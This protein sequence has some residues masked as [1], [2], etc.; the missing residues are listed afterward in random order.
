MF[1]TFAVD[2]SAAFLYSA[3]SGEAP[4]S[5]PAYL[6]LQFPNGL[7]AIESTVLLV[8]LN[9]VSL[10]FGLTVAMRSIRW[11]SRV[12]MAVAVT[13]I[14][15]DLDQTSRLIGMSIAARGCLFVLFLGPVVATLVVRRIGHTDGIRA[16]QAF[17]WAAMASVLLLGGPFLLR[18]RL[19][20]R[21]DRVTFA[22]IALIMLCVSGLVAWAGVLLLRKSHVQAAVDLREDAA[23]SVVE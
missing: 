17:T 19:R 12:V 18:Y 22:E 10:T 8:S 13:T 20:F 11:F 5:T 6:A 2:A 14:Y 1:T 23:T 16:H 7:F 3:S 9:S 15:L 4:N 21:P